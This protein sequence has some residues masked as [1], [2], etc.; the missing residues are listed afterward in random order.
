MKRTRIALSLIAVS[1]AVGG[2]YA[3]FVS[4]SNL[5]ALAAFYIGQTG[6]G[7]VCVLDTVADNCTRTSGTRCKT[8]T[9][10]QDAW[11]SNTPSGGSVCSIPIYRLP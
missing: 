11:R 9:S 6:S 8:I 5:R 7:P 3:S 10:N 4:S 1:S 2:A